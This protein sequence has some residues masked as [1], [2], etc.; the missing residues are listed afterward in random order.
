MFY[1]YCVLW[2]LVLAWAI[3][4][5]L[6]TIEVLRDDWSGVKE[7]PFYFIAFIIGW[8]IVLLADKLAKKNETWFGTEKPEHVCEMDVVCPECSYTKPGGK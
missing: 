1:L 2:A 8:P 3:G 4:A 6:A 7:F 5:I